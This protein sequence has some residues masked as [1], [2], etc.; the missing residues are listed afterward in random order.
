M[1]GLLRWFARRLALG[2]LTLLTVAFITYLLPRALHPEHYPGTPVLSGT[3]DDL[4]RG[5]LHFDWGVACGWPGCPPV[6]TMF[7]RGFAA[8][9]WLIGGALVLGIAAGLLGAMWCARRPHSRRAHAV[10]VVA[11]AVYCIPVYVVGLAVLLLFNPKFGIVGIPAF[12]DGEPAWAQPWTDPWV[13]FETLA[14]PTLVLAAPLAAMC[15]RLTL[16]LL[17]QEGHVPHVRTAYAKGVSSRRVMS[18]H[19][20]PVAYTQTAS[21]VAV[22]IPLI[23][24][25]LI[26][27]EHVFGVPGFFTHTHRAAGHVLNHRGDPVIDYPM[28]Q[29][30]SLWAAVLIVLLGMAVDLVLVRLDPRIRDAGLPG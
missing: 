30:I 27:V 21:F 2:A 26:L 24:L 7:A 1:T 3:L 6:A 23:V 14:V 25:N 19:V 22:S 29:A 18:R 9:L 8:D 15:L 12:F 10:E 28:I 13:W 17:R 5:F 11:T 4:E 20:A 16:A